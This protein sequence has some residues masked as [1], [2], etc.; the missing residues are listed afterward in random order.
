MEMLCASRIAINISGQLYCAQS[1]C[2]T[3]KGNKKIIIFFFQKSML[4][5][6]RILPLTLYFCVKWVFDGAGL[7]RL[8]LG[9]HK[10]QESKQYLNNWYVNQVHGFSKSFA[11]FSYQHTHFFLLHI[12]IFGSI[13]ILNGQFGSCSCQ[14]LLYFGCY[15]FESKRIIFLSNIIVFQMLLFQVLTN[16]FI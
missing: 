16:Y 7:A 10:V 8:F 15:R 9:K 6:F 13:R 4:L 2:M 3:C 12:I 11:H 14:F 1:F 5:A